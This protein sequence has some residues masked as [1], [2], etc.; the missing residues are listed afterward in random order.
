MTRHLILVRHGDEPEDDRI[1]AF[2]DRAGFDI[3]TF[4]PFLG[5]ALPD[6]GPDS[7][8]AVLYG[9][10]FS[11]FDEEDHPFLHAEARF[12]RASIDRGV[13]LLGI[14]QG[15]QQIAR[16]LGAEVGPLPGDPC[17]FGYYHLHP[18]PEGR[19]VIPASLVVS[20]SH[21]HMFGIP[22]G[23][24]CLAGSAIFPN[25]AFQWGDRTF[26]F[27]FHPEVTPE[28]FRRWQDAPWARYDQPG[29]QSRAE[30]DRLM[31]AHDTE[32]E[33]WF[34]SFLARLFGSHSRGAP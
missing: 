34:M 18:T 16:L 25:Q 12:A 6:P 20:Q 14:C 23:A 30:Q 3:L 11:V 28:G 15:A 7:A 29:A 17:E 13:P 10:P 19:D 2:A 5:E 33:A 27:Q 9:G 22:E 21:F 26:G 1:V 32:Q 8:G 4:R 24:V 31:A